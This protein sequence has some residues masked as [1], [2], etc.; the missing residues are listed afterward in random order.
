MGGRYIIAGSQLGVLT[1]LIKRDPVKAQ[2]LVDKILDDQ[3]V[4][5]SENLF[6]N[7]L[8]RIRAWARANEGKPDKSA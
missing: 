3:Q 7:D 6:Q 4:W 5:Y 2:K 1:V 8:K